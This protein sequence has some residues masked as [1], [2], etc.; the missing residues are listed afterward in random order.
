MVNAWRTKRR[1]FYTHL[2]ENSPVTNFQIKNIDLKGGKASV[3][4]DVRDADDFPCF[5]MRNYKLRYSFFDKT[6]GLLLKR[7]IDLPLLKP[8]FGTWDNNI[9]WDN[10]DGDTFELV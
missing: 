1:S 2:I 10:F 4:F 9:E 6:G 3:S 5:T 8:G 7:E